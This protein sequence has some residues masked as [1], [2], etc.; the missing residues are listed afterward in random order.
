MNLVKT[1]STELSKFNQRV[2]KFLRYGKSDVRVAHQASPF[3]L[4]SNP[5]KGMTAVFSPTDERGKS[6]VIGYLNR[7]MI[8]DVGEMRLYSLNAAGVLQTYVWLKKDGILLLGGDSK[9]FVEFEA[10]KVKWD[11]HINEYNLHSHASNGAPPTV[12]STSNID[13]AKTVK[14]K[15]A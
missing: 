6:V 15:T 4:D 7:D 5:P 13:D 3:G 9:H 8:A 2:I 11:A 10:L 12:Q 14:V 1:I